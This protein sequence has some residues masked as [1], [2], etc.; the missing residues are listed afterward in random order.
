MSGKNRL[1]VTLPS[2]TEIR[3]TRVFEAPRTLVWDVFTKPEH[4]RKWWGNSRL[5]MTVCE[6]D[7]RVGGGYRYVG[8]TPDGHDVPFK[9]VHREIIAP[10]R[11]VY[12]EVYD[13]EPYREFECLVTTVFTEHAGKT[14]MV[15]TMLHVS[16]EIRDTVLKTGMADGAGESYD[17][18]ER[19]MAELR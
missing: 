12:T 9:G 11:I 14:T 7:L 8:T 10:E 13:V 2:D 16:K 1:D 4:V 5:T 17:F 18:A 3:F 6:I 19:V 15:A